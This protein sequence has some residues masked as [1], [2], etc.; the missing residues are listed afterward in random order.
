MV[1]PETALV[2]GDAGLQEG[3]GTEK[4]VVERAALRGSTTPARGLALP[5]QSG[6]GLRVTHSGF[7]RD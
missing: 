6:S 7:S 5:E 1:V 2:T 4:A 3:R